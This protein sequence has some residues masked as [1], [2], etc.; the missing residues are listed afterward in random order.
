M[1]PADFLKRFSET[2]A[3][4]VG[5]VSL[6]TELRSM[7]EWDSLAVV[8]LIAM[9]DESYG[10]PLSPRDIARCRTIGDLQILVQQEPSS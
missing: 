6:E 9:V 3:I 1:D 4:P 8:S 5:E 10:K 7:Q 2:L